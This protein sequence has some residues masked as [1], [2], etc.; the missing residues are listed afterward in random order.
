[1]M[2]YGINPDNTLGVS[3]PDITAISKK[4]KRDH[5]LALSLWDTGVHEAKILAA[6][7]DDHKKL[8][9]EQMESWVK[10]FDSWTYVIR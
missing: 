5:T 6:L 10:D 2:R 3:M 4:Y 9:E 1:M 8:T 7:V